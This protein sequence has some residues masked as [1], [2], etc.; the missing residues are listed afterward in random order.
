MPLAV[1]WDPRT[2]LGFVQPLMPAPPS[3]L[4]SHFQSNSWE[5]DAETKQKPAWLSPSPLGPSGV[6]QQP[7]IFFITSR[8]LSTA[9]GKTHRKAEDDMS[10]A[11]ITD[12]RWLSQSLN[13]WIKTEL[14]SLVNQL[15]RPVALRIPSIFGVCIFHIP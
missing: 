7:P 5:L 13:L 12:H 14:L 6:N 11:A 3:K 1:L 8:S 10:G 15:S 9:P 2:H 4:H